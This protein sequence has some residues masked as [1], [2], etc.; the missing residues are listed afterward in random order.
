[1][2]VGVDCD[3]SDG[4][5]GAE[6]HSEQSSN[7]GDYVYMAKLLRDVDRGLQHQDAEGNAR[8]PADEAEDV[9]DT[10]YQEDDTTGPVTTREHVNRGHESKND[11]EDTSDPDELLCEGARCPH[12]GVA[13]DGGHTKHESKQDYCVGVQTKVI[14]AAVYS[15]IEIDVLCWKSSVSTCVY[16]ERSHAT[17]HIL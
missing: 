13:K 4:E 9:E 10:E 15:T 5:P 7:E 16:R 6:C 12:V 11:V 3:E 1:M 2:V 14:L 17:Y 8:N